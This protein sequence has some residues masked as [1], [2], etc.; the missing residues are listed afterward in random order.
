[1]AGVTGDGAV[2]GFF[3]LDVGPDGVAEV[4][5][6]VHPGQRRRGLGAELLEAALAEA[7]RRGLRRLLAVVQDTNEKG[8]RFFS[9]RG[10]EPTGVWLPRT[11]HLARVV[12]GAE[13]QPPLEITI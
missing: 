5:L 13:A 10:F 3:R 6:I 1:V 4:T 7:R 9:S 8:Y 12:H 11:I 2:H